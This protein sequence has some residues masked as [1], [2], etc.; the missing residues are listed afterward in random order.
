MKEKE[1]LM[2]VNKMF[3][4]G[5]LV[6]SESSEVE[7]VAVVRLDPEVAYTTISTDLKTVIN[8][9]NF[10]SVSLSVFMSVPCP[11]NEDQHNE[12]FEFCSNF[13]KA[14][15]AALRAEVLGS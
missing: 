7:K 15:I 12:A 8:T 1:I 10:S 13:C 9:G 4:E 14:K 3:K 6:T 2:Y 11:L 5:K